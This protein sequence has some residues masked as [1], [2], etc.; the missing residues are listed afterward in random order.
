MPAFTK[1]G[2]VLRANK[3]VSSCLVVAVLRRLWSGLMVPSFELRGKVDDV[4]SLDQS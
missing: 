2:R 4:R 1:S 3:K